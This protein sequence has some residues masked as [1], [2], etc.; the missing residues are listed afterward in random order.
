MSSFFS[1][2]YGQ[3]IFILPYWIIGIIIGSII[4]VFGK[5][6]LIN[7]IQKY[8]GKRYYIFSL[9]V[10]SIIGAISPLCMYGTIPI[11]ASLSGKGVK[12]DFLAAF[13]MS[14][15]L[16]NPQVFIYTI[17]LGYNVAIIRL[18]F[19]LMAGVVAGLCVSYFFKEKSFFSFKNLQARTNRDTHPNPLIRLIYNIG[20]NI[21][22]TGLYFFL[23]IF[24]SA[25]FL[26]FTPQ[27]TVQFFAKEYPYVQVF[28]MVLASIPFY[29]C[30]GGS[31]PLISGWIQLGLST[32]AAITFTIAGAATKITHLTALKIVLTTKH[33]FYFVIFVCLFAVLSGL[34]IDVLPSK[35]TDAKIDITKYYNYRES[36]QNKNMMIIGF[37]KLEVFSIKC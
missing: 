12:D 37:V 25:V 21:K 14:S 4:S 17:A 3:I 35:Y 18:I 20:R 16:L 1:L 10:A 11:A 5:E 19:C 15:V 6:K 24:L 31:I 27:S 33:M 22:A 32:G 34:I 29:V 23:G 26:Y 7:F 8:N 13:M 30:G 2:L 28:L 36:R 9:V